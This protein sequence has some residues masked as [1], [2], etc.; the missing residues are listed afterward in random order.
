MTTTKSSVTSVASPDAG[1][2]VSNTE[3]S[4][5]DPVPVP[6]PSQRQL[7]SRNSRKQLGSRQSRTRTNSAFAKA[8]VLME[9]IG[10]ELKHYKVLRPLRKTEP[11]YR[12]I[13]PS[14][15]G[16][17]IVST[18]VCLFCFVCLLI[19]LSVG[20]AGIRSVDPTDRHYQ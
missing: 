1:T 17:I 7:E 19:N 15:Q 16:K 3:P 13:L 12:D 18:F 14:L 8:R 4:R 10:F 2:S 20:Q 5:R 11:V 6:H 9:E